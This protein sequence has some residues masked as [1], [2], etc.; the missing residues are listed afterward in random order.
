MT[1]A[2]ELRNLELKHLEIEKAYSEELAR[3]RISEQQLQLRINE[4]SSKPL[5]RVAR[6]VKKTLRRIIK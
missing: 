1:A 4:L 3:L 6:Y 2:R 5:E